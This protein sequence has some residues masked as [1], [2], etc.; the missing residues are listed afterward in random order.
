MMTLVEMQRTGQAGTGVDEYFNR[1]ARNDGKRRTHLESVEAQIAFVA[2]LGV[3][4]ENE[5]IEYTLKDLAQLPQFLQAL[6]LAWRGG[7]LD[8]LKQM[9]I[10]P[11]VEEFPDV[12]RDLIVDRNNAWLIQLERMLQTD[13]VELVLVGALHLAGPDGL[14][15]YYLRRGYGCLLYTSPSPRDATLSRMPSSA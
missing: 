12:Y 14:L 13:D 1:R 11:M 7:D 3:G 9:G 5:L 15:E 8:G 10:D 6:K 4:Q 2:D